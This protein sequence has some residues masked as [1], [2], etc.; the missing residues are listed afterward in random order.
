MRTTAARLV[1]LV[2]LAMVLPASPVPAEPAEGLDRD[3]RKRIH[4]GLSAKEYHPGNSHRGLQASN[5]AHNLRTYF[6]PTGI[7]LQDRTAPGSPELT[8]LSLAVMGRG[9][10]LDP[11]TRGHVARDGARVEIRRAGVVEWYENSAQGL[12][13]GFTIEKQPEGK[14]PLVLELA[15]EGADAVLRGGSVVLTTEPGRRLRYGGLIAEDAAG[16]TLASRLEV[17]DPGRIRLVVEDEGASY[18]L[19]IDPLLTAVP[20]TMLESDQPD[21][22]GFK[23]AAF[24]G[25]VSGAGDVNGDGF[26][27]VVVS[28]PGW[29]GG[30]PQEGA[31]FVFLGSAEGII[32][33][34][35]ATAHARIESNQFGAQLSGGTGAGD[36]N[37]DGFDDIIVGAHFYR[38]TIAGGTL[39]VDGAAFVFHGGPAG[40]TGTDPATADAFIRGNELSSDLGL[41]VSAAGDVN[42][43]G[44]DDVIVG[45]PNHGTPFP[46][47]ISPN[48]RSGDHGAA[49]VFHGGP[50]G[51][52]GTGFDD[53]DTVLLSYEDTG[54]P[55]PTI[56]GKIG[57]VAGA[58]DVNGDGFSDVVLGGSEIALF[59]GSAAGIV[60]SD[61]TMAQSRVR[62]GGPMGF[63]PFGFSAA[64][65]GDVN[66]DGFDDIIAG[67]PFREIVPFTA[68]QEGAVFVFHGTSSGLAATDS[69]QA[70]TTFMGSLLAE[71]LGASVAGIGDIDGDGYGDVSITARVYPGSLNNEGVSYVF[72]G[73][74]SGLTGNS[75]TDAYLRLGSNQT[76]A[77]NLGNQAAFDVSGAGDVNGDGFADLIMGLGF[78]DAGQEN[79]GAAFVYLGG[80]DCNGSAC[81]CGGPIAGDVNGDCGV[82]IV[83]SLL[84]AQYVVGLRHCSSIADFAMCDI[85]PGPPPGSD[86]V[87]TI[88]DALKMA[89]CS[90]GLIPCGFS[91][92]TVSCP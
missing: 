84:V 70:D 83:D 77:A 44:F 89:Q 16:R 29:D 75:P 53:A 49:L 12:E 21:P 20:D 4:R 65:A 91:A 33:T 92:G 39:A 9:D 17:P 66:G 90:V 74:P 40:I 37:G 71:W 61:L 87:C 63:G 80:L 48:Q 67:A 79:E 2:S 26:E 38:T 55:G 50:T 18:P 46:S 76:G 28:A 81:G 82:D 85:H 13:Q 58:G 36:V 35:P 27:D 14:G 10:R 62:P 43:D 30:D 56:Y 59:V 3:W 24:G 5:R 15:V 45:V 34:D 19:V 60:G 86:G 23:P 73:G 6:E 64:A 22:A 88:V 54:L 25:S 7:R 8:A 78:Y 1:Q 52:T 72:R 11:I 42:G 51:I 32:G 57:S 31:V 69:T 41:F 68:R 47:N